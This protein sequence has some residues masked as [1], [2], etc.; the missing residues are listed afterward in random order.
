M[1]V[2]S[3]ISSGL[4]S[5]VQVHGTILQQLRIHKNI[6]KLWGYEKLAAVIL[7]QNDSVCCHLD[8]LITMMLKEEYIFDLQNLN[9]LNIG[10]TVEEILVS[11][12]IMAESCG[13]LAVKLTLI[14]HQIEIRKT[15][16]EMSL[17]QRSYASLMDQQL[18]LVRQ[19]GTQFYLATRC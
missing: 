7:T 16:E 12:R 13:E 11:D 2:S 15:L 1:K 9:K 10:Q 6:C 8:K 18:E 5:L 19:M 3:E 17:L 4:S 14:S